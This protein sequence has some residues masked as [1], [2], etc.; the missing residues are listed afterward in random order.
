MNWTINSSN[1]PALNALSED[2]PTESHVTPS[3]S[4]AQTADGAVADADG[5]VADADGAMADRRCCCL[6][7][8][9]RTMAASDGS[10]AVLFTDL[11]SVESLNAEGVCA[12]R[13]EAGFDF[14]GRFADERDVEH[15]A[16]RLRASAR[17]AR[18]GRATG[19]I[20]SCR[21]KEAG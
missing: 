12:A 16:R 13:G 8:Q 3:K 5:A 17:K 7:L 2:S 21:R 4:R 19:F 1:K 14:V 10:P 15:G 11:F 9:L 6:L 20:R 18:R